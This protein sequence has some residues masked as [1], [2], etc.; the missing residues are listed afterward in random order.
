[1]SQRHFYATP[2]DLEPVLQRAE[3]RGPFR[4]ALTGLF[5]S[6]KV[7]LFSSASLPTLGQPAAS[8]SVICPT[9]LVI[10]ADSEVS[11][12]AIPQ[13]AGGVMYAVDQLHNPDSATLTHGGFHRPGVL[14]SGRVAPVG[15][16]PTA[17]RVQAAFSNAIGKL[18]VRVNAFYVGPGAHQLLE[19]GG[20]LTFNVGAPKE[21]D[22]ERPSVEA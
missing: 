12:R 11:V 21:Y 2:S 3:S 15:A 4:Y 17:K 7:E 9:Y 13:A 20:R 16:T 1:M 19:Q 8:Q 18:F 5:D 22:L 10:P 14:I 6:P